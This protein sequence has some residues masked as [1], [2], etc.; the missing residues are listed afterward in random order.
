MLDLPDFVR[1]AQE[2]YGYDHLVNDVAG[3]LCELDEPRVIDLLA[4]A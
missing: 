1:K 2:I 3:S 4:R